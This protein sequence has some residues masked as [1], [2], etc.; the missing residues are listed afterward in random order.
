ML[1]CPVVERRVCPVVER[2]K[3]ERESK[4]MRSM[5]QALKGVRGLS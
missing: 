2:R 5:S 3:R 1:V 4:G